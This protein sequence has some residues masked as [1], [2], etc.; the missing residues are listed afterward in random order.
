MKRL[1]SRGIWTAL[2]ASLALLTP[3][4]AVD[5]ADASCTGCGKLQTDDLD[6]EAFGALEGKDS[7]G[8]RFKCEFTVNLVE[9]TFSQSCTSDT[10]DCGF[11]ICS[12][13]WTLVATPTYQ[14][15]SGCSG[16]NIGGTLPGGGPIQGTPLP[17]VIPPTGFTFANG[18]VSNLC[19]GVKKV[20]KFTLE[21][22]K[23][24]D[25]NGGWINGTYF[26]DEV[27]IALK[28]AEC[29]AGAGG[30]AGDDSDGGGH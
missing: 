23:G 18:S 9:G 17:D 27:R 11:N 19:G 7:T 16:A 20:F 8:S 30:D 10:T 6:A 21:S 5:D 28:C 15:G 14:S 1:L 13:S 24:T 3:A 26:G 4:Y 29:T 12:L 22:S 2:F 25:K